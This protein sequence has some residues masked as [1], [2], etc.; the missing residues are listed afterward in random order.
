MSEKHF[1]E[2]HEVEPEV[3][4]AWKEK[5]EPMGI[6]WDEVKDAARYGWDAATLS[7]YQGKNF[8]QIEDDLR[9]HW[10]R[11][12]EASEEDSW[13][14]VRDAVKMGFEKARTGQ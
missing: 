9:S 8:D 2:W 1:Q 5:F 11:P 7:E 4:L 14:Y 13:D 3:H 12:E 6:N 10:S